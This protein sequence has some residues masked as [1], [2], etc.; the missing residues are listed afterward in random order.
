[1]WHC[2]PLV[3]FRPVRLAEKEIHFAVTELLILM[4]AFHATH[5]KR[6]VSSKWNDME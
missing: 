2:V 4:K 3:N 1:M 5:E 6:T